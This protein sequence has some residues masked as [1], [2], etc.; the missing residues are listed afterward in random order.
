MQRHVPSH[1]YAVLAQFSLGYSPP[2]GRLSTCYA[3]VRHGCIATPVRLACVKHA[4][5]V[6]SEPGSNSR[7][8]PD[9]TTVTPESPRSERTVKSLGF[10]KWLAYARAQT[11]P[12]RRSPNGR[13]R[14]TKRVLACIIRLSKSRYSQASWKDYRQTPIL[15]N[16]RPQVNQ[17]NQQN[18]IILSALW[19]SYASRDCHPERRLRGGICC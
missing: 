2:E 19:I 16:P 18:L 4:A 10:L 1:C 11:E 12:V 6:R 13:R 8:K 14:K 3:P 9:V 17:R 7:L 5:S 15:A